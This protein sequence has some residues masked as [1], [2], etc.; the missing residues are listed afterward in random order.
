MGHNLKAYVVSQLSLNNSYILVQQ[1]ISISYL[2]SKSVVKSVSLLVP[3]SI[4]IFQLHF[5]ELHWLALLSKAILSLSLHRLHFLEYF[6]VHR[7]VMWKVQS[8]QIP[9]PQT[10]TA[11]PTIN[12]SQYTHQSSIFVI[13]NESR[14]AYHYQ[15]KSILSTRIHIW[16]CA[17]YGF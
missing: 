8:S 13:I 2:T 9:V 1:N 10:F 14:L 15:P 7:E 5:S 4:L 16:C 3:W 12:H 17:L 11:S 6:Y